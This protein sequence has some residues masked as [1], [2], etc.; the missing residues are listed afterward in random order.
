MGYPV[1]TLLRFKVRTVPESPPEIFPGEALQSTTSPSR[2]Q[3]SEYYSGCPQIRRQRLV[4]PEAEIFYAGERVLY[5]RG[6][7]FY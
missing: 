3:A 4:R 5:D 2:F 1:D 6:A 7:V